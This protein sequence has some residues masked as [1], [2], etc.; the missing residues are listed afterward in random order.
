MVFDT[1]KTMKKIDIPEIAN[2]KEVMQGFLHYIDR[3][4][5]DGTMMS[6]HALKLTGNVLGDTLA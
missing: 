2:L 6:D 1:L 4:D 3:L 5:P